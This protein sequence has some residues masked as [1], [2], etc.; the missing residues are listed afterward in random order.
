MIKQCA[1]SGISLTTSSH[2]SN[3]FTRSLHPIMEVSTPQ[4]MD[5]IA[6]RG[7]LDWKDTEAKLLFLALA[8]SLD[9]LDVTEGAVA[10]PSQNIIASSIENLVAIAGWHNMRQFPL[11]CYRISKATEVTPSNER[12]TEFPNILLSIIANREKTRQDERD[13]IELVRLEETIKLLFHKCSIGANKHKM[14]RVKTADW[15]IKSTK[16]QANKE[17]VDVEVRELWHKMLTTPPLEAH[18]F[19]LVD[20]QELDEFMT[21][22][23]PHGC[24]ASYEVMKHLSAMK[25]ATTELA[26]F[27]GIDNVIQVIEQPTEGEPQ[28]HQF[29]SKLEYLVAKAKWQQYLDAKKH[30]VIEESNLIASDIGY[31]EIPPIDNSLADG[32]DVSL[33]EEGEDEGEDNE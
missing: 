17:R 25:S 2:F 21:C 31:H 12:M 32:Q 23:L 24:S 11:P 5:L 33:D 30:E 26:T 14:L 9:M 28:P 19:Q 15:A 18:K 8:N 20:V 16:Q 22:N 29:A 7:W 3:Y 13:E 6:S 1:I 27:L 10:N 4:L